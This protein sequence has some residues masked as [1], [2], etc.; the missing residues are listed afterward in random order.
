M[1]FSFVARTLIMFRR[2]YTRGK[3]IL[4]RPA[5]KRHG[6]N[7]LFDPNSTYSYQTIEVGDDVFIAPGAVLIASKSLIIIGNKVMLGPNVTVMGG[8]HNTSKV[9]KFMFDVKT[10]EPENDQ[11]VTIEDDVWVGTGAIILKGVTVG[12]GCIVAAGGVVTKDTI[13]YSVLGRGPGQ[14][15]PYA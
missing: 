3:M 5:F 11:P 13:S 15:Y 8:N 7:F 14:V 4:M 1:W 10:K 6:E 9:G 2:V 12:R